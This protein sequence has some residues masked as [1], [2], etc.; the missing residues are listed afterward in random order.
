MEPLPGHGA[1][2]TSF[3]G[4]VGSQCDPS[5]IMAHDTDNLSA[6][7]RPS[8]LSLAQPCHSH[9]SRLSEI[10]LLRRAARH[11]RLRTH[12]GLTTIAGGTDGSHAREAVAAKD[13]VSGSPDV[14]AA[15]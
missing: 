9:S 11:I 13:A 4:Q 6:P 1:Y 10:D 12:D 3:P 15:R 14:D 8:E 7:P 2:H 5:L